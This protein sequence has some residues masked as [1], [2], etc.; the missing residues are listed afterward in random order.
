MTEGNRL[1]ALGIASKLDTLNAATTAFVGNFT[2]GDGGDSITLSSTKVILPPVIMS[3]KIK[4]TDTLQAR[5]VLCDSVRIGTL[6]SFFKAISVLDSANTADSLVITIG[7][8]TW[9]IGL[10]NK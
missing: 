6:G 2:I 4:T 9:S 3:G 7:N 8:K 1:V 10:P 5:V